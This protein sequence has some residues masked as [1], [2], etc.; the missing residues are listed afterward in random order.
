M[1]FSPTPIVFEPIGYGRYKSLDVRALY[2][3]TDLPAG[4]VRAW[5]Q[6]L[7]AQELNPTPFRCTSLAELN[8]AFLFDNVTCLNEALIQRTLLAR[9]DACNAYSN[10]RHEFRHRLWGSGEFPHC[11]EDELHNV[12]AWGLT[13]SA[14]RFLEVTCLDHYVFMGPVDPAEQWLNA[15]NLDYLPIAQHVIR[16]ALGR[17]LSNGILPLS[18]VS[19]M[20]LHAPGPQTGES[21]GDQQRLMLF[22]LPKYLDRALR[23][24]TRLFL[25]PEDLDTLESTAVLGYPIM[26]LERVAS[27]VFRWRIDRHAYK[28]RFSAAAKA[29]N[30]KKYEAWCALPS[31]RSPEE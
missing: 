17:D 22:G 24:N 11:N 1:D 20:V 3:G 14:C 21:R 8:K 5:L 7:F 18:T 9:W 4:F 27:D 30:L 15:E 25:A 12:A 10:V 16:E 23:T 26:T 19:P 29:N 28:H 2:A 31:G 13:A 6:K